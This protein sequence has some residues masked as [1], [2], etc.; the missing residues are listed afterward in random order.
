MEPEIWP[1]NPKRVRKRLRFED[2]DRFDDAVE[3][4]EGDSPY[5]FEVDDSDSHAADD[6]GAQ[7]DPDFELKSNNSET[8]EEEIRKVVADLTENFTLTFKD[9]KD[10]GYLKLS[11][12]KRTPVDAIKKAIKNARAQ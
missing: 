3:P 8:I 1:P 12:L 6:K 2:A 4:N 10:K 9:L 7:K 11:P 5:S